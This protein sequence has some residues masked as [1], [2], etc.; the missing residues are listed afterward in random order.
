ELPPAVGQW[1]A[2]DYRGLAA[3]IGLAATQF[4]APAVLFLFF[5]P[6][7]ARG[8]IVYGNIARK[9]D[10]LF[11][12][13]DNYNRPFDI[14]CFALFVGLLGVLAARRR[15][16]VAPRLG[17]ALAIL[18]VTYLVL[19]S[20]LMTG[21]GVDRR[22]PVALFA[23]LIAATAP[24][25]PRRTARAIGAAAAVMFVARMA[26]IERVWH[27]ADRIYA[28][29]LAVIDALPEGATLAVAYPPRDV[30]ASAISQ[31]HVATLAAA[32]RGAFVPT[33]FAY[34]G[35]QP[36][37]L[38]PPYDSLAAATSPDRLWAGFVGHDAAAR[39]ASLPVLLR[40]DFIVLADR[41]P[42]AAPRDPCLEPRAATPRFQLFKIRDSEDCRP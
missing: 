21:A 32:R 1:R 24:I 11:S 33:V 9:A 26:V 3:R 23:L 40:Y 39:R 31:L 30:N 12:V 34:A 6:P 16:W 37:A 19:P 4:V 38:R 36:L 22:L 20:Q 42:F 8:P 41:E 2:G 28:A 25:L 13:F 14:A 17:A 15:L 18:V 5:Q 10:L 27:E 29:D 35:Q 7:A